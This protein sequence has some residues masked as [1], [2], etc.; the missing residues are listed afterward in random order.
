LLGGA[1]LVLERAPSVGTASR[2][3]APPSIDCTCR[4]Q[5]REKWTDRWHELVEFE[6]VPVR[7]SEEAVRMIAPEL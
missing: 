5:A 1:I 2:R 7:T 3:T 6:I 4:C